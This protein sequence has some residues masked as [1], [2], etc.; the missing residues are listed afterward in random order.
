MQST[1]EVGKPHPC[2]FKYLHTAWVTHKG[3]DGTAYNGYKLFGSHSSRS[4]VNYGGAEAK[5]IGLGTGAD[6]FSA[7]AAALIP[8][9]A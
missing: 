2:G 9:H 3:D 5:S 6:R 1:H 8:P 4:G 7:C